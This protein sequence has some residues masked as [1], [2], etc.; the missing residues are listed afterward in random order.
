M[1]W[2]LRAAGSSV[3]RLPFSTSCRTVLCTSTMGDTPVM[4]TVSS[5]PPT[6]IST[7]TVAVKAPESAIASRTT[8]AKPGR[9]NVAL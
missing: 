4:V 6:R 9:V 2:M 1:F 5:M 3:I 7:F 8:V